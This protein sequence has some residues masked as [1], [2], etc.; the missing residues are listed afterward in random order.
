MEE[1][2]KS[3]HKLQEIT[4]VNYATILKARE[5]WSMFSIMSEFIESTERLSDIN[6][7]VTIFGSAR[8]H[9]DNPYYIQCMELSRRLSDAG[10]AVIS[11]GGPGIMAAANRDFV[12]HVGTTDVITFSYFDDPSSLFPGEPAV[13]LLICLDAAWREG[14]RR[15]DSNYARETALYIVHGLLHSAGEDD[16]EPAPRRRMRRRER[17]VL[18]GL[19]AAGIDFAA[20]FP[21]PEAAL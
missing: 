6:P 4:D 2:T 8:I 14:A 18:S 13:E 19:E 1:N 11:G 17:E 3:V 10:F 21:A 16:L 12:G 7:A 20:I 15:S 9:P 5:S